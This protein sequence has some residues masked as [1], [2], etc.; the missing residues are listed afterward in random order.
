[1]NS[2][3]SSFNQL[4]HEK[5]IN[6]IIVQHPAPAET[7]FDHEKL[8]NII[9]NLVSNAFKY[10]PENGTITV[11]FGV[12]TTEMP[13]D[14][15]QGGQNINQLK[16]SVTDT[17]IG[18]PKDQIQNIFKSFYRVNNN[19]TLKARGSGIG[20]S[21]T[22]ELVKAH[23]GSIYVE[24]TVG[25]GSTFTVKLPCERSFYALDETETDG[26]FLPESTKQRTDYLVEEVKAEGR[27]ASKPAVDRTSEKPLL[28]IV[29]DNQDLRHFISINLRGK[30]Q[31][32]EAQ[33]G[34]QGYEMAKRFSPQLIISDIMM[35]EMDGLELCTRIKE[36]ILTSHIPVLLLTARTTVENWIEGLESGADDYIPKPFNLSILEA[37]ICTTI[38]NRQRLRKLFL[39]KTNAEPME[40]VSTS[41]DEKFLRKAIEI[42]ETHYKDS[43]FCVEIFV[44]KMAVSR[45]LLH[46]KL[47]AILDQSAGD[48]ITHIRLKK[49]AEL[50]KTR[51]FNISE[52]AYQ[53]GFNDPK[54]FSRIFKR[55]YGVTPT[56]YA[57]G[58]LPVTISGN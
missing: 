23:Y 28:L 25:K 8:E 30:Y 1:M 2:I 47:S 40:L 53:V 48:F 3:L 10:T 33:N 29:E 57:E 45:S 19:A 43:E 17:G 54:Y 52:V 46:K 42:V 6:Y 50:L 4:A 44:E 12:S 16:I 39:T 22:R 9:Y 27:I 5:S 31:M 55:V 32:L 20:L 37:K 34:K 38:Q 36:N 14:Q 56:E 18:I 35:P 15:K 24:S 41:L 49:S 11:D 58:K 26:Q 51:S 7:W 21:L 13:A